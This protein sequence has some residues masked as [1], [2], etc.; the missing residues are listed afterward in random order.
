MRVFIAKM[1]NRSAA[2][3]IEI[4]IR[5]CNAVLGAFA[6]LLSGPAASEDIFSMA[7]NMAADIFPR[8]ELERVDVTRYGPDRAVARLPFAKGDGFVEIEIIRSPDGKLFAVSAREDDWVYPY[9]FMVPLEGRKANQF[10][11]CSICDDSY[12]NTLDLHWPSDTSPVVWLTASYPREHEVVWYFDRD[13]DGTWKEGSDMLIFLDGIGGICFS[14]YEL[15]L[16]RECDLTVE[17]F[18]GHGTIGDNHVSLDIDVPVLALTRDT[19]KG[20]RM[21]SEIYDSRG[22]IVSEDGWYTFRYDDSGLIEEIE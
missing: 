14:V 3:V 5:V 18:S 17:V 8:A 19:Q 6:I 9:R 13:L 20:F 7:R 1:E 22:A 11:T 10:R 15:E 16:D 12:G 21:R 2:H 4:L